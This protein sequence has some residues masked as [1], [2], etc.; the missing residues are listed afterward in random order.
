MNTA[1]NICSLIII[2]LFLLSCTKDNDN[3]TTPDE[4]NQNEQEEVDDSNDQE[5]DDDNDENSNDG[6]TDDEDDSD[7]EDS[8]VEDIEGLINDESFIS[9]IEIITVKAPEIT[10][11]QRY[12]ELLTQDEELT[13]EEQDEFYQVQ[14][15]EN[16]EAYR[17]EIETLFNLKEQFDQQFGL[18]QIDSATIN[19]IIEEAVENAI[20]TS[21]NTTKQGESCVGLSL[22]LLGTDDPCGE[23]YEEWNSTEKRIA[24]STYRELELCRQQSENTEEQFDCYEST[25]LHASKRN[26][27]LVYECCMASD[28][29]FDVETETERCDASEPEERCSA[30]QCC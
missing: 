6:D 20:T 13:N 19:S 1:K 28:C 17:S 9:F 22:S 26:N 11:V 29:A 2:M 16:Y 24:Q 21:L 23:C 7:D 15:Y 3:T 8:E 5:D 12:M 14:G 18:D 30:F 10:D 25:G 4:N 27:D